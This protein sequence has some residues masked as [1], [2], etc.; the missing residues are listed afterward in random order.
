MATHTDLFRDALRVAL[1]RFERSER[2]LSAAL[3]TNAA[4]VRENVELRAK[5]V[6]HEGDC[7][8]PD[9]R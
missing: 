6:V 9:V 2:D 7:G 3:D 5:L 1:E 4:L 8:A